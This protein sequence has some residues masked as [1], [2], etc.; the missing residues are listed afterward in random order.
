MLRLAKAVFSTKFIASGNL[1]RHFARS[2]KSRFVAP[3]VPDKPKKKHILNAKKQEVEENPPSDAEEL[4]EDDIQLKAYLEKLDSEEYDAELD[5]IILTKMREGKSDHEILSEFF[6]SGPKSNPRLKMYTDKDPV[7][8]IPKE[9]TENMTFV[10]ARTSLMRLVFNENAEPTVGETAMELELNQ[11]EK[12]Q[13]IFANATEKPLPSLGY[14]DLKKAGDK[15]TREEKDERDLKIGI[16]KGNFASVNYEN[17]KVLRKPELKVFIASGEEPTEI[18]LPNPKGPM[19]PERQKKQETQLELKKPA[20]SHEDKVSKM[21]MQVATLQTAK[22]DDKVFKELAKKDYEM[23]EKELGRYVPEAKPGDSRLKHIKDKGETSIYHR[24]REETVRL[25]K[26]FNL[27]MKEAK[28]IMKQFVFAMKKTD[29]DNR[30]MKKINERKEKQKKINEILSEMNDLEF[31]DEQE[32]R[33]THKNIKPKP[34]KDPLAYGGLPVNI[35]EI[36]KEEE[37]IKYDKQ[38]INYERHIQRTHRNLEHFMEVLF[39]SSRQSIKQGLQQGHEI[40][41]EE[42]ICNN[43]LTVVNVIWTL[44][45]PEGNL[46]EEGNPLVDKVGRNLKKF[47]KYARGKLC[48]DLGFKYAPEMRFFVSKLPDTMR[49]FQEKMEDMMPD[50]IKKELE[51]ELEKNIKTNPAIVKRQVESRYDTLYTRFI[52]DHSHKSA[53]SKKSTKF[54]E[55]GNR[56]HKHERDKDGKKI[57]KINKLK[58]QQEV[59]DKFWKSLRA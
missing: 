8:E 13:E 57:K 32:F 43:A 6:G 44:H 52:N 3:G 24:I 11:M 49:E 1:S 16:L 55:E 9:A 35:S 42:V 37:D 46:I 14:S 56:I 45:G 5:D 34:K 17:T 53:M 20:E 4:N 28:D 7:P 23:S 30:R 59:S 58:A 18:D 25:A 31:N 38:E 10:Q 48:R 54:D 12:M 19:F 33:D 40:N 26:Q 47:A 15:M 2:I 22:K 51:D 29:E 36:E 27:D 41:V 39:S 21:K 50:L